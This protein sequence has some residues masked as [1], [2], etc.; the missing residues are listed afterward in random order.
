[1]DPKRRRFYVITAAVMA[2]IFI[3]AGTLVVYTEDSY[4]KIE[5]TATSQAYFVLAYDSTNATIPSSQSVTVEVLPNVNVTIT[6]HPNA[7]YSVSNWHISGAE[8]LTTGN[9]TISLL[10]GKG[11]S[12][13]QVTAILVAQPGPAEDSGP[14]SAPNTSTG[15]ASAVTCSCEGSRGPQAS[16]LWY[17]F[18]NFETFGA[19]TN[20]Q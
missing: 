15:F 3:F 9:N 5:F 12:T 18:R 19:I 1:M 11:G 14:R 4:V 7:T 8:V 16:R 17:F 2:I 6:A 13:V 10:T 20:M